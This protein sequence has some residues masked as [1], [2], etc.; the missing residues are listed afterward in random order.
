MGTD[1][2]GKLVTRPVGAEAAGVL[3]WSLGLALS[4]WCPVGVPHSPLEN[5][6]YS[7]SR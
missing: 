6:G 7:G 5:A 4:G 2:K 1:I 3:E